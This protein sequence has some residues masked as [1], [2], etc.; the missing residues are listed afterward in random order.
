MTTEWGNIAAAWIY[1]TAE[2]LY[3]EKKEFL[4]NLYKQ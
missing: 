4:N 3:G 1:M 2:M